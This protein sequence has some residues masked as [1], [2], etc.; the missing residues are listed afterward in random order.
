MLINE[1]IRPGTIIKITKIERSK[2]KKIKPRKVTRKYRVI[3]Q[4]PHLV[5]VENCKGTRSGIS[6]VDLM[7]YH[8]VTQRMGTG[9]K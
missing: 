8:L 7:L 3:S 6:N 4:H 2:D 5:L 9:G 1:K